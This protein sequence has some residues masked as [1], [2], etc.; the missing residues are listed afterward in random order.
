M[1]T[2]F[3]CQSLLFQLSKSM[4]FKLSPNRF[5]CV[6]VKFSNIYIKQGI[7]IKYND[8]NAKSE[9][10]ILVMCK[11]EWFERF[12]FSSSKWYAFFISLK[13]FINEPCS[14]K[15]IDFASVFDCRSVHFSRCINTF[16]EITHCSLAHC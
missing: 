3:L 8:C 2:L 11:L 10:Y 1:F 13:K 14:I 12:F 5:V 9:Q 7:K 15:N 4:I 16:S 6:F